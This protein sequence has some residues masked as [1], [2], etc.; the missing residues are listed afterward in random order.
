MVQ[1]NQSQQ[2]NL[3]TKGHARECWWKKL[4][5]VWEGYVQMTAIIEFLT[6][7]YENFGALVS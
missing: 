3:S 4:T 7:A 6:R 2:A 5:F 1:N